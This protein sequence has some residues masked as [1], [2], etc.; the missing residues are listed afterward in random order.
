MWA[1]VRMDAG[2]D[3]AKKVMEAILASERRS[4]STAAA[5]R[6]LSSAAA[7][8]D[9]LAVVPPLALQAAR[10]LGG[11]A[12][13]ACLVAPGFEFADFEVPSRAELLALHPGRRALVERFTRG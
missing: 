1:I 3:S 10:P 13:A 8:G 12:L 11:W 4:D 7:G 9:P 2:A 5:V 6:V